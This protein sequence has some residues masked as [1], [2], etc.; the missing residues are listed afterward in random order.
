[1]GTT[2][3][4][5]K[6]KEPHNT[7]LNLFANKDKTWSCK[8]HQAFVQF[9]LSL[10]FSCFGSAGVYVFVGPCPTIA[11]DPTFESFTLLEPV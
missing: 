6:I 11:L 7:G 3:G 2:A 9:F 8:K 4:S 5:L 1:M 10:L